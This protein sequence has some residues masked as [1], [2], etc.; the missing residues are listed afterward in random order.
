[1]GVASVSKF[2]KSTVFFW[3]RG[4]EA[5][6]SGCGAEP[7]G[8]R[9][10]RAWCRDGAAVWWISA[11]CASE[12]AGG[13]PCVARARTT[14]PTSISMRRR[15]RMAPEPVGGSVVYIQDHSNGH[16]RVGNNRSLATASVR[17]GQGGPV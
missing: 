7:R 15:L 6:Q 9:A 11:R 10:R 16:D 17:G 13:L 3:S 4:A 12:R 14:A 8:G 1:M 2:S 5:D